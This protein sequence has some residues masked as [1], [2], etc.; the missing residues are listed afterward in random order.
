MGIFGS[1]ISPPAF[2]ILNILNI[3]MDLVALI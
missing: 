2:G 1:Q 3:R